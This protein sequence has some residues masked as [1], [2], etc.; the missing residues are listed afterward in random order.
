MKNLIAELLV[1]L[2]QKE[3]ESKELVAQVE[4]LEIVV[5]ALLRQ[6][7]KP[8]QKA[9]IDNV[10]GALE[11]A[12]PDSQVPAEDAELLQQYVKKLLRHPRS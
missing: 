9:L 6:M 1:K 5:T 4:A 12:R 10:E 3:E 8:E 11:K 2:A 7:A